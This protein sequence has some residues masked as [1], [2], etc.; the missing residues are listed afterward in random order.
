MFTLDL[1]P[2]QGTC[3]YNFPFSLGL[4]LHNWIIPIG[5]HRCFNITH[6]KKLCFNPSLPHWPPATSPFSAIFH[7]P[8][9][10]NYL[11]SGN[12]LSYLLFST[13]FL[14]FLSLYPSSR[15]NL[16]FYQGLGNNGQF[17]VLILPNHLA[18]F[19]LLGYFLFAP[20]FPGFPRHRAPLA[21]FSPHWLCLCFTCRLLLP[22]WL[23]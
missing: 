13:Y 22:R 20:T 15:K 5:S 4:P 10:Q 7:N 23:S 16:G 17:P 3:S 2:T 11:Y 18:T 6:I 21:S 19:D 1:I 9:P 8:T 14:G 12:L